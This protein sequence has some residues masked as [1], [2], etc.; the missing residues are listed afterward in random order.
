MTSNT[1]YHIKSW[2][3]INLKGF[4]RFFEVG[5]YK[6]LTYNHCIAHSRWWSTRSSLKK[7]AGVPPQ[8]TGAAAKLILGT[9]E[10]NLY[11]C[12]CK[13]YLEYFHSFILLSNS[14]FQ[15]RT[16]AVINALL[17]SRLHLQKQ[18]F[19][20]TELKM[21]TSTRFGRQ[22]LFNVYSNHHPTPHMW[23]W[24]LLLFFHI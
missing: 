10:K 24:L 15:W 1:L 14:P 6:V 16:E 17:K 7:Q 5:L 9:S 8:K 23:M 22:Y 4:F 2:W 20:I 13:L 18:Q 11:Q 21:G 19:Y 12:R 3:Q